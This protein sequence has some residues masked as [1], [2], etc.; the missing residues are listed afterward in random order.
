M[1]V[2]TRG[3]GWIRYRKQASRIVSFFAEECKL[4]SA[5]RCKSDNR[6]H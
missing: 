2:N 5:E 4:F 3:Q 1:N 6:T